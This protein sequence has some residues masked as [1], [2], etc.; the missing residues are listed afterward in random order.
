M[1]FEETFMLPILKTLV[2]NNPTGPC[3][4]KVDALALK[5]SLYRYFKAKVY[6]IW[7]HGPLG[8]YRKEAQ[9]PCEGEARSQAPA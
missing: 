8:K 4:Q 9:E 1:V 5:Y 2:V 6:T 7:V 3:T